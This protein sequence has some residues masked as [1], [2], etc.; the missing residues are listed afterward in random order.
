MKKLQQRAPLPAYYSYEKDL[1]ILYLRLKRDA[2]TLPPNIIGI[3]AL[4]KYSS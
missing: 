4:Q 1:T 3:R 2:F